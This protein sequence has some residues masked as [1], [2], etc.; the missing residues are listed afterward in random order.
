MANEAIW[1]RGLLDEALRTQHKPT[2]IYMDNSAVYSLSRD[3]S[4]S[5]KSRH[6]ERR[7]FVV[8]EYQH[9][10]SIDTRRVA[11]A[12]N[13]SDLFTKLHTRAPFEK[14]I[15]HIMNLARIGVIFAQPFV[16][17]PSSK[18]RRP[19]Y[20]EPEAGRIWSKVAE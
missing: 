20:G 1:M 10:G 17:K 11:S 19:L 14:M 7:H 2:P 8:R 5:S 18:L 13:W 9:D 12:D 3:F 6:I 4:S 16:A 15:K